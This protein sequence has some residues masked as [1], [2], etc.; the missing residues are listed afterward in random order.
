MEYE[1]GSCKGNISRYYY[2]HKS[3]KCELFVYGGCDGN[4]NNFETKES[5]QSFANKYCIDDDK[6]DY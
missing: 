4:L 1:T 6:K 3:A 5:C 2:N